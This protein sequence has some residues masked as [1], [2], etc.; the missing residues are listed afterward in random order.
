[1]LTMA[2]K[3]Y[4]L[5]IPTLKNEFTDRDYVLLHAMFATLVEFIE[6]EWKGTVKNQIHRSFKHCTNDA[7][8][9]MLRRENDEKLELMKLY[10]WW[11]VTYPRLEKSVKHH[12]HG[13]DLENE[14]MK[15]LIE[16]RKY[17]WT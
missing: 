9:A 6:G 10:K 8:I 7:E 12:I 11:K 1:M 17:M 5:T 2:K 15:R 3:S 14:K 4:K 13:Y 16:L